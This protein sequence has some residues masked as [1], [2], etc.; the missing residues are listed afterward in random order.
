MLVDFLHRRLDA[1]KF[2]AA[3][4]VANVDRKAGEHFLRQVIG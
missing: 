1:G 3:N 4:R 2:A